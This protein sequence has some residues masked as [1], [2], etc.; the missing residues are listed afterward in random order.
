MSP[1]EGSCGPKRDDRRSV[2]FAA[3]L[4]PSPNAG[5]TARQMVRTRLGHVVAPSTLDDVLLV[6]SELV[7]NAVRHGRGE[8]DLQIGCDDGYVTG[9]VS[10]EGDGFARVDERPA[11]CIG[12]RGLLIVEQLADDWGIQQEPAHVWFAI[13]GEPVA[14]AAP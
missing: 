14:V 9:H 2:R 7:T 8:V 10:D 1:A 12:H 13:A 4:P 3:R 5:L 11:D 6:V